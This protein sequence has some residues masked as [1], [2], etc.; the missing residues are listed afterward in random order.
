[1]ITASDARRRWFGAFFL[2][3]ALGMLSWGLIFLGPFL[4][5]RPILFVIYWAGCACFTGISM[6]IALLDMRVMRRRSREEQIALAKR[7]FSEMT[8]D[9]EK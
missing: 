5:K 4:F 9:D 2:L 7:A 6:I 3:I 1:M 8:E